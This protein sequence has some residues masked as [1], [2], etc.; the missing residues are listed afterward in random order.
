LKILIAVLT[1]HRF[2]DRAIAVRST[3]G[4]YIEG[5]DL[6]F[7]LGRG[8]AP[9]HAF[10][11][12][13]LLDVDDGYDALPA[14][15]RAACR[16][17]RERNYDFIYKSDD[18][19]YVVPARLFASGFERFDYVGRV[20][21]PSG[22]QPAPYCSGFGYWLSARAFSIMADAEL[23][24]DPA[25]DRFVANKLLK[26]GI[27]PK[28]DHRY[29]VMSSNVSASSVSEPPRTGNDL[30][31]VC[32][33]PPKQML[34]VHRQ[35]L[36]NVPSQIVR[37]SIP[38]GTLSRVAVVVKTFLRDPYLLRCIYTLER[39]CTDAKLVIVDDGNETHQKITLYAE[40]RAK[41]HVCSWLPFDSGFG[42]KANEGVE[43]CD[44]DY[45]L[46]ASDDF[47]FSPDARAGI[48]KLVAVLDADP[49]M[50]IASGRVNGHPYESCFEFSDDG[51]TVRELRA[52]R[53]TRTLPNGIVYR[54]CDLT[55][56]YSLIRRSALGPDRLHW[57]GGD[58]KIGGGE[59]GAFFLDAHRLGYGVCVVD[60][61]TIREIPFNFS[62][63]DPMYPQFRKRALQPGRACLRARGIEKWVLQDGTLELT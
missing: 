28:H 47:E 55:V 25:E 49:T 27:R 3:W 7:F 6:R 31:A 60:G 56:N 8:E 38:E 50:H 13:V 4:R 21:G 51:R 45:V 39:F 15:L 41:G 37:Y 24:D 62:Q 16:W 26:A 30:I 20:R 9:P 12:E 1:C 14:K 54:V 52:H 46:I 22:G 42:A 48:E 23:N 11:D 17:A 32:E 61:V 5:A 10:A 34:D 57:D 63:T 35:F 44:R 18:D 59:H 53:E 40:L 43:L 2:V 33:F 29:A 58:V 36:A 19:A